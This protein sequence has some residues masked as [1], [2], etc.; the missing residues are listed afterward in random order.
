MADHVAVVTGGGRAIGA[1]IAH[2]LGAEGL[3]VVI[4][5]PSVAPDGSG[6][7]PE[8]A[9]SGLTHPALT[10]LEEGFDLLGGPPVPLETRGPRDSLRQA[11]GA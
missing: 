2:R 5:D 9:L 11:E 10:P 4:A 1:A 6:T 7:D 3:A 8:P